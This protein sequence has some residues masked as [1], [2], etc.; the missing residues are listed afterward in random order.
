[1]GPTART[2]KDTDVPVLGSTSATTMP[3]RVVATRVATVHCDEGGNGARVAGGVPSSRHAPCERE[4]RRRCLWLARGIGSLAALHW[5]PREL[6]Q[7][8]VPHVAAFA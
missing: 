4:Q 3:G 2:E 5:W 6:L 8:N 1:M 7:S